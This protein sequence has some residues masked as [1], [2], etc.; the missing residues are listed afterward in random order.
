MVTKVRGHF[1]EV[2]GHCPYRRGEPFRVQ[3]QRDHPD[4]VHRHQQQNARRPPAHQRLPG[5]GQVPTIAFNSTKV[6]QLDADTVHITGDLTI[7]Q[8]TRQVSIDF[9]FGGVAQDPFGNIRIGFEGST[10]INRQGL[11]RR[12]PRCAGD[13]GRA[14]ERQDRHRHRGGC[15]QGG[16]RGRRLIRLT[17]LRGNQRGLVRVRSGRPRDLTLT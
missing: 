14:G 13:R 15:G 4:R 11:R 12:L 2:R 17:T 8:T 7:K 1:A 3:R 5:G 16:R 6:E 9:E 10:S